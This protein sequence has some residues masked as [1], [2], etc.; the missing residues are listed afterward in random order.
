MELIASKLEELENLKEEKEKLL[1]QMEDYRKN[2]KEKEE[3]IREKA[4]FLEEEKEKSIRSEKV[5]S[6]IVLMLKGLIP[7]LFPEKKNCDIN[8]QNVEKYMT[9]VGLSIEQKA[10]I[11]SYRNCSFPIETENEEAALQRHQS[12]VIREEKKE[13]K[14][15][16]RES[17]KE[18]FNQ[19]TWRN[20]AM[21]ISCL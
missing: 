9:L 15:E 16:T 5:I 4:L 2:A 14:D 8:M 21:R 11:L 13:N 6:R 17:E 10:T 3:T 20:E 7:I 1:N 18:E 19:N 12:L